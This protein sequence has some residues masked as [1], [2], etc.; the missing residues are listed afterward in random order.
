MSAAVFV[1]V[2]Q[3]SQRV[4]AGVRAQVESAENVLFR[5]CVQQRGGGSIQ[6]QRHLVK[7]R[8]VVQTLDA[9][10]RTESVG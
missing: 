10:D 7:K 5:H 3:T 9:V 1:S 2:A 4:G 8:T 6:S